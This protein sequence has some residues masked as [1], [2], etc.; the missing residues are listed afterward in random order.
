MLRETLSYAKELW[1]GAIFGRSIVQSSLMTY[2]SSQ[3]LRMKC[4]RFSE[5]DPLLEK[6]LYALNAKGISTYSCCKGHGK[7]GGYLAMKVDPN[8]EELLNRVATELWEVSQATISIHGYHAS[9][10]GTVVNIYFSSEEKETVLTQ[11]L[12]SMEKPP[13]KRKHLF[14]SLFEC[15][16]YQSKAHQDLMFGLYMTPHEGGYQVEVESP[17]MFHS[18]NR[19]ISLDNLERIVE[20]MLD[21]QQSFSKRIVTEEELEQRLQVLNSVLVESVQE[22]KGSL[23]D[24]YESLTE[25]ELKRLMESKGEYEGAILELVNQYRNHCVTDEG[26]QKYNFYVMNWQ[27]YL[28]ALKREESLQA[29]RELSL[30]E[31]KT[32][33]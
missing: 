17:F 15:V 4:K 13:E 29:K 25:D 18:I 7:H 10:D 2:R 16:Y 24:Y 1:V 28:E 14:Q 3:E 27:A 30:Q 8:Q 31:P 11:L 26:W 19:S 12:Q 23:K 32:M 22:G 33:L 5:R 21:M 20:L 6:V 9:F